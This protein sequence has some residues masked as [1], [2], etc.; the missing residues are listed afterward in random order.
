MRDTKYYCD[1]CDRE[2]QHWQLLT[3]DVIGLKLVP[4]QN[5]DE[6]NKHVCVDCSNAVASARKD[7]TPVA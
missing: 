1:L 3:F 7:F 2:L 4:L 6:G 5:V